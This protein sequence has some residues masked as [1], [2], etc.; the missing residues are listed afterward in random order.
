MDTSEAI[1]KGLKEYWDK[2]GR[3]KKEPTQKRK[4][5]G[6]NASIS[7]IKEKY[8]EDAKEAVD[9]FLEYNRNKYSIT[10]LVAERNATKSVKG[11]SKSQKQAVK[12]KRAELN[13]KLK[14]IRAKQKELR[15]EAK[16]IKTL[17]Q[18]KK[19][20][21]KQ[22]KTFERNREAIK[23]TEQQI[24]EL[25]K[26]LSN[27][28][29]DP[30]K[31][32]ELIKKAEERMDKQ[33]IRNDSLVDSISSTNQIIK[34]KG[35]VPK[36]AGLPFGLSDCGCAVHLAE[37]LAEQK[38]YRPLNEREKAINWTK[39]N[40]VYQVNEDELEAEINALISEEGER[41]AQ[42]VENKLNAGEVAFIALIAFMIFGKLKAKIKEIYTKSY[43][44]G[45]VSATSETKTDIPKTPT[46][47]KQ[48]INLD[49]EITATTIEENLNNEI[50]SI[51]QNA[52]LAGA[53]A[54]AIASVIRNKVKARAN[55]YAGNTAGTVGKYVN[56]GREVVFNRP[57]LKVQIVGYQRSEV[58]DGRTCAICRA[59]DGRIVKA[60]DPFAKLTQIH[61]RCRGLQL[62]IYD[63]TELVN[64]GIPKS[65]ADRFETVGG[66]PVPNSFKQL[67][68]DKKDSK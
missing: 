47:I 28:K 14:E 30:K 54:G 36:T 16:R 58:L 59:M 20:L 44:E 68:D 9:V 11:M 24:K 17:N 41:I 31:I 49:A 22:Q 8:G 25:N 66:V 12:E 48:Q 38:F 51:V 34:N 26:R 63:I 56:V 3:K 53:G 1:S 7:A 57:E 42:Q 27:D 64:T 52:V 55:Q 21:A 18:A 13:A 43:N 29:G 62:P 10:S 32:K 15:V 2:K 19:K 39:L 60:D 45:V 50:R 65:L 5:I 61:S 4:P 35:V 46:Q 6:V 33:W 67:K 40:E 37:N 23:K